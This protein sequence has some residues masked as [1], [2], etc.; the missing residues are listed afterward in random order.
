MTAPMTIATMTANAATNGRH[1]TTTIEDAPDG[2]RGDL[3]ARGRRLMADWFKAREGGRLAME[4]HAEL[5]RRK[6]PYKVTEVANEAK[7][8]AYR[9]QWAVEE[10]LGKLVA[11]AIGTSHPTGGWTNVSESSDNDTLIVAVI[12]GYA[13]VFQDGHEGDLTLVASTPAK[14]VVVV[15]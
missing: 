4:H 15:A 11:K 14:N 9:R 13:L 10:R 3:A 2:S 7:L 6:L 12:G 8:N 5:V 1:T